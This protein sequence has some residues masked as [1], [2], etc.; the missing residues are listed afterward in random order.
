MLPHGAENHIRLGIDRGEREGFGI[1]PQFERGTDME[2]PLGPLAK[3]I[4]TDPDR[5][6]EGSTGIGHHPRPIHIGDLPTPG[7][8]QEGQNSGPRKR[9]SQFA[10]RYAF[11]FGLNNGAPADSG[12]SGSLRK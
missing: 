8:S 9:F 12:R 3:G 2:Y 7:Q 1:R 4:D 10:S 11:P 5:F 6:T